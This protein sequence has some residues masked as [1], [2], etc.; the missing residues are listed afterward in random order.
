MQHSQMI[1]NPILIGDPPL[2]EDLKAWTGSSPSLS[3]S[4]PQSAVSMGTPLKRKPYSLHCSPRWRHSSPPFPSLIG[5]SPTMLLGMV[6]PLAAFY[7]LMCPGA[8]T[9]PPVSQLLGSWPP[10]L[11]YFHEQ[12]GALLVA[13]KLGPL[14]TS[15]WRFSRGTH[16]RWMAKALAEMCSF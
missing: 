5:L 11:A 16:I 15:R 9:G 1:D 4:L 3:C 12:A 2:L 7:W 8:V 14:A 13:L 10:P 6:S